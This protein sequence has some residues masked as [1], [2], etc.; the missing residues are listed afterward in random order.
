MPFETV[1]GKTR[2]I[3]D[4][5][6]FRFTLQGGLEA[7]CH[8]GRARKY[9]NSVELGT[10]FAL[11]KAEA[12]WHSSGCISLE[13]GSWKNSNRIEATP[14][15]LT[16]LLS[17]TFKCEFNLDW[18]RESD[19]AE[20]VFY[21]LVFDNKK[22]LKGSRKIAF[23]NYKRY[24]TIVGPLVGEKTK[25]KVFVDYLG[26][27]YLD[28]SYKMWNY[29]ARGRDLFV[30]GR[31]DINK[32]IRDCQKHNF[33]VTP[34]SLICWGRGIDKSLVHFFNNPECVDG[35]FEYV[36]AHRNELASDKW[37][38][39]LDEVLYPNIY[40]DYHENIH[41]RPQEIVNLGARMVREV[42]GYWPE[43][44]KKEAEERK[45]VDN[46]GPDLAFTTY[47]YTDKELN[48]ISLRVV[49]NKG[50]LQEVA[51][52][53]QNCAASYAYDLWKG[54]KIHVAAYINNELKALGAVSVDDKGVPIV[55]VWDQIHGH[56]NSRATDKVKE[57]YRE[58]LVPYLKK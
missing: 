28:K 45:A 29:Y 23:R 19:D 9:H 54:R 46:A 6:R 47:D 13:A 32:A 50:E 26:Y 38:P 55:T 16:R 22:L 8:Y 10:R 17:N 49:R 2:W 43:E 21:R 31:F 51:K 24:L 18:I 12:K 20:D 33:L 1:S 39:R 57:C 53:L 36:L 3:N 56:K 37:I 35:R 15:R 4:A 58:Y 52:T 7:M 25:R 14:E 40:L 30:L 34:G 41:L 11:Y 48:G 42:Y 27:S 44:R 5:P